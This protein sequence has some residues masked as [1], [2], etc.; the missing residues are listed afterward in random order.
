[1]ATWTSCILSCERMI[2]GLQFLNSAGKNILPNILINISILIVRINNVVRTNLELFFQL[3]SKRAQLL[4]ALTQVHMAVKF[5]KCLDEVRHAPSSLHLITTACRTE[6]PD[7]VFGITHS[8]T[9]HPRI[10]PKWWRN[11]LQSYFWCWHNMLISC[12]H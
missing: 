6:I 12:I 5:N 3:F 2:P 4:Q 7:S 11:V 8:C 10:T 9:Q 1:M